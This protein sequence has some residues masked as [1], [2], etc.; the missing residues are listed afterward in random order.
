LADGLAHMHVRQV[1][2]RGESKDFRIILSPVNDS[3]GKLVFFLEIV[4]DVSEQKLMEREL[5]SYHERLEELV[6]K[7]TG[8]L[9]E[10]NQR[11]RK[12]LSG[13]EI[14]EKQLLKTQRQL[15]AKTQNLEKKNIAL[16]EFMR[17]MNAEEARVRQE[18]KSQVDRWLVPVLHRMKL[19]GAPATY[20]DVLKGNIEGIASAFGAKIADPM[21]KLTPREVE[22]S[23]MIRNGLSSKEIARLL[24]SST[25]TIDAHRNNIRKKLGLANKQ[26]NLITYLQQMG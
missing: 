26:T 6:R 13:R 1:S 11:L 21:L 10:I 5:S 19:R 9:K 23:G 7:R 18:V 16:Q 14:L 25:R 12:E 22:V 3:R 17:M 20:V 8:Q 2:L 4:E 24:N 15:V